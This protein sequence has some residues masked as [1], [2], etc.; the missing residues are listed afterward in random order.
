[1]SEV[2]AKKF[3]NSA[4]WIKVRKL[5]LIR[6]HHCCVWCGDAG[7]EVDHI[8]ELTQ[9]NIDDPLISINMRNLRTLCGNCHN[10]RH[11]RFEETSGV[12]NGYMFDDYGNI[13]K[14]D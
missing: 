14:I 12:S 9:S 10:R 2:W 8:I 7:N 5:V 3:Y 1:M 4:A 6:D 13:I 11:G